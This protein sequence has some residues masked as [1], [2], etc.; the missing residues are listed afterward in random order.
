MS[1]SNL[2]RSVAA[3]VNRRLSTFLLLLCPI[4][5]SLQCYRGGRS[6][7]SGG[8]RRS[9]VHQVYSPPCLRPSVFCPYLSPRNYSTQGAKGDSKGEEKRLTAMLSSYDGVGKDFRVLLID[10]L[11]NFL[12]FL[13]KVF[14]SLNEFM[15]FCDFLKQN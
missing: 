15:L 6:I 14:P 10:L 2:L 9:V 13:G 4:L 12:I 11:H 8:L 3:Q 1:P 5:T 7:G